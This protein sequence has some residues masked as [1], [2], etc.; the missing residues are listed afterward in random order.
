MAE[1]DLA[2]LHQERR[3]RLSDKHSLVDLGD[4]RVH[5]IETVGLS[6]GSILWEG[7]LV[8]CSYLHSL[9]SASLEGK[10]IIELG[11]GVGLSGIYA[12]YRGAQ[13]RSALHP[14]VR[15]R[16]STCLGHHYGQGLHGGPDAEGETARS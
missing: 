7:G 16:Q 12:A 13:V 11:A 1:V 4:V 2:T 15:A 8:L 5:M 9:P 6:I 3:S 10:R 14:L